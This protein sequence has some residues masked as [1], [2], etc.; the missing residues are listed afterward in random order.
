VCRLQSGHFLVH[1]QR[2]NQYGNDHRARAVVDRLPVLRDNRLEPR[3][4]PER[5][6]IGCHDRSQQCR[7]HDYAQ[8]LRHLGE[9][10]RGG[11]WWDR[12]P[13]RSVVRHDHHHLDDPAADHDDLT[14][15]DIPAHHRVRVVRDD[16]DRR[17]DNNLPHGYDNRYPDHGG[18]DHDVGD[19]HDVPNDRNDVSIDH[20]QHS[21]LGLDNDRSDLDNEADDANDR[22]GARQHSPEFDHGAG[23]EADSGR[24]EPAVH[25]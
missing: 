9:R 25:R 2:S 16:H 4:R 1:H 18:A 13:Q 20:V 17:P 19:A 5:L 24:S 15:D 10:V 7:R 3:R 6:D 22:S 8:R 11:R 12:F 23:H 21:S 14:P